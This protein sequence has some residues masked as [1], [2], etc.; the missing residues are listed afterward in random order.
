MTRNEALQVIILT[1]IK[2]FTTPPCISDLL[3]RFRQTTIELYDYEL[4][5]LIWKMNNR[6]LISVRSGLIYSIN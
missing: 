2:E 4:S 5:R 3:I 6:N 1:M